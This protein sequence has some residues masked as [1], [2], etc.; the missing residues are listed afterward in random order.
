MTALKDHIVVQCN[1]YL[2][3]AYSSSSSSYHHHHHHC[4]MHTWG[5]HTD[6]K[7]SV[8]TPDLKILIEVGGMDLDTFQS[9]RI[10]N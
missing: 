5:I 3:N 7:T 10:P 8:A 6:G 1:A 4:A 9:K 2:E